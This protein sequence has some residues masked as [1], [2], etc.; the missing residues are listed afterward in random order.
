MKIL[1][2]TSKK[3]QPVF[4]TKISWSMTFKEKIAVYLYKTNTFFEQNADLLNITA[5]GTHNYRCALKG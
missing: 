2:R 3:T 4:M 1:V 5:I